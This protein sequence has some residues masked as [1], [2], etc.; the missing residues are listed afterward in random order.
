MDEPQME[1]S[2]WQLFRTKVSYA[3]CSQLA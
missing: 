3:L 1:I 2:K